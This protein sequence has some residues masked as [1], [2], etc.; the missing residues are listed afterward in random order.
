MLM[1]VVRA[2]THLTPPSSQVTMSHLGKANS[3]KP[4]ALNET[5]QPM[6]RQKSITIL[7]LPAVEHTNFH[8]HFNQRDKMGT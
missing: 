3:Y 1:H 4:K 7:R 5:M 8:P 6:R 2:R